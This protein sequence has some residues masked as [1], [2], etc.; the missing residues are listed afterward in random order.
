[1]ATTYTYSGTGLESAIQSGSGGIGTGSSI[2]LEVDA[3]PAD[4]EQGDTVKVALGSASDW[5]GGNGETAYGDIGGAGANGGTN[6]TLT[7]RGQEGTSAAS[8]SEGDPVRVGVQGRDDVID[9][10]IALAQTWKPS[11]RIEVAASFRQPDQSSV[12]SLELA[13]G[14]TLTIQRGSVDITNQELVATNDA[15]ATV[16]FPDLNKGFKWVTR[17]SVGA[18]NGAY[19]ILLDYIDSNNYVYVTQSNSQVI[20]VLEK[21]SGSSSVISA[22]SVTPQSI[23]DRPI[24]L[25]VSYG[26]GGEWRIILQNLFTDTF[27]TSD[28]N[29]K[30]FSSPFSPGIGTNAYRTTRYESFFIMRNDGN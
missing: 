30:F 3:I 5:S 16:S 17:I 14:D 2:T 23:H 8:W 21:V 27:S 6:I 28:A 7:D 29:S 12:S 24:T 22:N 10:D 20:R 1:M 25:E 18:S 11:S 19:Q 15:V 9:Q 13:T 26:S 4:V